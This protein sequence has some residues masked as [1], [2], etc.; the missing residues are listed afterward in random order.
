MTQ[1]TADSTD[2]TERTAPGLA[3][4]RRPSLHAVLGA[5]ALAPVGATTLVRVLRNSPAGLAGPV[6]ALSAVLPPLALVVP[7]LALAVLG[8]T[9]SRPATRV[10]LLGAGLF[11]LLSL[12][13]DAA[14][15]PAAS[16]LVAAGGAG[17][18]LALADAGFEPAP[19]AVAA[20][21]VAALTASLL[22][23]VGVATV[24]LR[25]L[26]AV[27]AFAALAALP[28]ARSLGTAGL[29]GW[30]VATLTVAWLVAS[31][32]FVAGA[33]ILVAFAAGDVPFVLL[34][35]GV[36]GGVVV[37]LAALR[38]RQWGV[39]IGTLLL[40]SAGAPAGLARGT[41]AVL[42]LVVLLATWDGRG[43][44][45]VGASGGGTDA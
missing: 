30:V 16:A 45:A 4:T 29:V 20:L 24:A 31:A 44:S 6:D 10:A 39:A 11:P 22:G 40:L 34:A 9:A 7:A 33:V 26:G 37:A 28:L 42:G 32:P 35:G 25:S 17:V 13:S 8:A 5:L 15:L 41:A 27:L 2:A 43:A 21:G 3:T 12:A 18:A 19:T 38:S 36:G 14:W 1:S 23:S